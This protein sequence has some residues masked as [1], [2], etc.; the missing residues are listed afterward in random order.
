MKIGYIDV[1]GGMR[2]AYGAGVLDRCLDEGVSFPYLIGVSAGAANISS[3]LAGQRGRNLRFYTEYAFRPQYMSL[4]NFLRTRS[5]LDLDYIY[6]TLS[7]ASG[8]DPLDFPA[9]AA[10]PCEFV[11]VATDARAGAPVYFH[12]SDLHQDDYGPVKASSCVPV[13]DRPYRL[14]GQPFFDGGVSDPI[15][16]ERA[17]QDGC[18]RVV[19]VLTRPR[20]AYRDPARDRLMA[21]RL[22][23][24]WPK[25]GEALARRAEVYNRQLDAAK[26]AER[27]GRAR[28]IAPDDIGAMQTLT[29][30]GAAVE[31]LYHKGYADA[32]AV[33]A[34]VSKAQGC[35]QT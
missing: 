28:I 8:E 13:L 3:F 2:G 5:Y 29:R 22:R 9:I 31:A 10:S 35:A 33:A 15:P 32:G 19:V 6:G 24:S 21:R 30:D 25:A 16:L 18:E 26:E 14:D 20:D 17:F 27:Q 23:L 1:G 4:G 11:I 7:N 12:K 34:F